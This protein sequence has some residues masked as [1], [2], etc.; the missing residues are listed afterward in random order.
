MV[1]GRDKNNRT[2]PKLAESLFIWVSLLACLLSMSFEQI[3]IRVLSIYVG[4]IRHSIFIQSS[5]W[6]NQVHWFW[7]DPDNLDR[8]VP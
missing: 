3:L 6:L 4:S 1:Q 7:F 8:A 2:C 5:V